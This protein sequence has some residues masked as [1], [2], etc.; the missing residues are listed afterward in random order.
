MILHSRDNCFVVCEE[1]IW[2]CGCGYLSYLL[3]KKRE[4][5]EGGERDLV[6]SHYI[7]GINWRQERNTS[8]RHILDLLMLY[9]LTFVVHMWSPCSLLLSFLSVSLITTYKSEL[10]SDIIM[11]LIL[12]LNDERVELSFDWLHFCY[13]Y[14]FYKILIESTNPGTEA[15]WISMIR[16]HCLFNN[17]SELIGIL[18]CWSPLMLDTWF[19]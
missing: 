9:F 16:Q 14:T 18:S 11:L 17:S 8:I 2:C 4:R 3:W 10:L 13:K 6:P 1:K 19:D 5:G 15:D 12:A 7:T